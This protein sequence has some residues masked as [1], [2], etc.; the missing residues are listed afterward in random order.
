MYVY[1]RE[2]RAVKQRLRLLIV[3]ADE[4]SSSIGRRGSF[5]NHPGVARVGGWMVGGA[6]PISSTSS[7]SALLYSAYQHR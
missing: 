2:E 3:M 7:T 5:T 4:S 1:M 6:A